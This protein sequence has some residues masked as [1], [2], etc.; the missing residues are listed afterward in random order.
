MA[1]VYE[2]VHPEDEELWNSIGWRDWKNDPLSYANYRK[3]CIDRGRKAYLK[4][5][6][7]FIDMP[8]YYDFCYKG[9]IV[10]ME[11][12]VWGED[13]SEPGGP[14]RET[15]EWYIDNICIPESIWGDRE[16]IVKLVKEAFS[17]N[18]SAA[19][20]SRISSISVEIENEPKRVEADYNGR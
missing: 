20:A 12:S 13:V 18:T 3:W 5:I 7:G 6:G 19:P 2:R 14:R 1:F 15:L 8:D 17:V 9:V 16:E 11:V 10:R 4:G